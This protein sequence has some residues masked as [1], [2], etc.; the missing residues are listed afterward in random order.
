MRVLVRPC[1]RLLGTPTP[2]GLCTHASHTTSSGIS[3]RGCTITYAPCFAMFAHPICG[4]SAVM[5]VQM[6]VENP[7]VRAGWVDGPL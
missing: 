3:V 4:V 6:G 7:A 2:P 1:G 5:Q